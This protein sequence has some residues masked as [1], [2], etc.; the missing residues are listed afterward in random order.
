M[1]CGF[2]QNTNFVKFA[3]FPPTP[4]NES[5]F[6]EWIEAEVVKLKEKY[7]INCD[8]IISN[9]IY[10]SYIVDTI[11]NVIEPKISKGLNTVINKDALDIIRNMDYKWNPGKSKG[12]KVA[13]QM[14][15]PFDF[16]PKNEM[17]ENKNRKKKK[18]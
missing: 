9:A 12:K 11:G 18:K 2:S 13:V 3:E 16:C 8:S 6:I 10:I 15:A 7:K 1:F 17:I 5:A 14:T 4:V